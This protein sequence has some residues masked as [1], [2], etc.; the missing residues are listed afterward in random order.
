M[1]F[2]SLPLTTPRGFGHY[3]ISLRALVRVLTHVRFT[4]A[5][6]FMYVII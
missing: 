1:T 5:L 6:L 2:H 4:H 3:L